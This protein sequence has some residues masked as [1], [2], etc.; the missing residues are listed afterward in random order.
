MIA[1]KKEKELIADEI[2]QRLL[3]LFYMHGKAKSME[4]V[5]QVI[6]II[7]ENNTDDMLHLQYELKMVSGDF[8]Q[9]IGRG[10]REKNPNKGGL[11]NAI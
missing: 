1:T 4:L 7:D 10:R 8:I 2:Y 3:D 11:K 5:E 9:I 6:G